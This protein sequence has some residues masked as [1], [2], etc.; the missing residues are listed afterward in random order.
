M[1][2]LGGARHRWENREVEWAGAHESMRAAS[3]FQLKRMKEKLPAKT[4]SAALASG[5]GRRFWLG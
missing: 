4:E 2:P 3:E 1:K 5:A